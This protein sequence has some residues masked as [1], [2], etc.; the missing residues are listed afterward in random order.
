MAVS[1]TA[2]LRFTPFHVLSPS[3]SPPLSSLLLRETVQQDKR[4]F[5]GV[6]QNRQSLFDSALADGT[7]T[8]HSLP[9]PLSVSILRSS[10]VSPLRSLLLKRTS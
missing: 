8:I 5:T 7:A 3:L 2:P 9:C 1:P 6:R 10:L 4:T